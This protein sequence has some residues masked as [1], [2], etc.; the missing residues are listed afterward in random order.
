MS[1][2]FSSATMKPKSSR[3]VFLLAC[4][5]P[6]IL[7]GT[8]HAKGT[9]QVIVDG[10]PYPLTKPPGMCDAT[11]TKWGVSYQRFSQGPR[12]KRRWGLTNFVGAKQ[13]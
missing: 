6:I 13:L 3:L 9:G 4:L 2:V 5:V 11:G 1:E 7:N 8:L 12:H 10:R